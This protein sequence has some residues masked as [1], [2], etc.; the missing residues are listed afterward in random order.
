MCASS[1]IK[2]LWET[3]SIDLQRARYSVK[4]SDLENLMNAK[5]RLFRTLT[6]AIFLIIIIHYPMFDK[7]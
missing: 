5:I 4:V 3:F 6:L 1:M 7:T 2:T